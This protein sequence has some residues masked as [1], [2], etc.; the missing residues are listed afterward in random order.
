[1]ASFTPPTYNQ[2]GGDKGVF[3]YYSGDPVGWSVLIE[4]G[5]ATPY[6]GLRAPRPD[7]VAAADAFFKGGSTYEVTGGEQTI[8]TTAGYTVT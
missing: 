2:N 7:R 3:R 6:P 5:V 4:G 1:M 8:L